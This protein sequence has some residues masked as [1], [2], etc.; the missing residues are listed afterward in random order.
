VDERVL[1][2]NRGPV[3]TALLEGALPQALSM[4]AVWLRP[5]TIRGFLDIVHAR[6]FEAFRSAFAEWPGPTL[7]VVYADRDGRIGWQLVGQLPRRKAGNGTVPLPAADPANGWEESL[8]PFEEMPFLSDPATGWVAT[9]NGQ[10]VPDGLGPYL[11]VDYVDGYRLALGHRTGIRADRAA[12]TLLDA[13]HGPTGPSAAR[14]AGGLVWILELGRRGDRVAR[15]GDARSG[16]RL[17]DRSG[18]MAMGFAA[19]ADA[20]ASIGCAPATRSDLQ[21]GPD[22]DGRRQQHAHASLEWTDGAVRQP[23][24]PGERAVRRRPG[25]PRRQPFLAR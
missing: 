2:T 5:L 24:I 19:A 8:V 22:P 10:P 25:E 17:W 1:V 14:A 18:R 6:S 16:R 21:P 3:I 20:R 13:G 11:G 12:H 15:R 9:A 23:R 4:S 7:N